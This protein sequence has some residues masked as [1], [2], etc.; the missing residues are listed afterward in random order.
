M[1]TESLGSGQGGSTHRGAG[2]GSVRRED[3]RRTR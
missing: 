2:V 1:K 3:R